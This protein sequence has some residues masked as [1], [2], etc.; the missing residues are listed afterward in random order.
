[1]SAV[2]PASTEQSEG[3]GKRARKRSRFMAI[4]SW[5][6]LGIVL[7]GFAPTFY[8]RSFFPVPPIPGYLYV[9]GTIVTAWFVLLVVQTS[10]VAAGNTRVHRRLGPLGILI[11]A[12]VAVP[13]IWFTMKFPSRVLQQTGAPREVL[14]PR[15]TEGVAVGLTVAIMTGAF[16]TAAFLNTRKPQIHQR[17]VILASI[18]MVSAALTRIGG[19]PIF[20]GIN[21]H[22]V[23]FLGVFALVAALWAHDLWKNGTI[24][25]VSLVG[26]SILVIADLVAINVAPRTAAF[27]AF[28]QG[29]L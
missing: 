27:Q 22:I 17:F 25:V 7:L 24:H 29:L 10:F 6:L 3:V 20:G 14:L 8:L 4:V 9:H 15:L 1:M 2:S 26:G 18:A 21:F 12:L 11:G 23:M 5:V 13:G 28:V 19:A 16:L